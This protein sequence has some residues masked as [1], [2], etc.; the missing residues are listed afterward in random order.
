MVLFVSLDNIW[1]HWDICRDCSFDKLFKNFL[2]RVPSYV[3]KDSWELVVD[4]DIA[5]INIYLLRS[6]AVAELSKL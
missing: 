6:I 5:I 1:S 3:I 2:D 4:I